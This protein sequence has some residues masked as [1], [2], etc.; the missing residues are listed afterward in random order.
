MDKDEPWQTLACCME[1][2]KAL[3]SPD[4][5][6]YISHFPVHQV[7]ARQ[8]RAACAGLSR[9][10]KEHPGLQRC[11]LCSTWLGFL[12]NGNAVLGILA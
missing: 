11:N 12:R 8:I 1:I 2:A 3:R 4:P 5:A 7:G 9:A 6:A 10:G